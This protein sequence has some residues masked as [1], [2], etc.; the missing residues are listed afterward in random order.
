M[1]NQRIV[2]HK[3]KKR[4]KIE[5]RSLLGILEETIGK[6]KAPKTKHKEKVKQN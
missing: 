3:M 6:K 4:K 5:E 2:H 1:P